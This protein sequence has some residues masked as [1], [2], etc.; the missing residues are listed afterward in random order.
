MHAELSAR[1]V[2]AL[3]SRKAPYWVAPLLYCAKAKLPGGWVLMYVSPI[4]GR[5]V[6]MG[7]G[8]IAT[9]PLK[10]V[11][12]EALEYRLQIARGRCPLTER[13]AEREARNI[14]HRPR[15]RGP[16]SF[17]QAV[18]AFIEAH[19][20]SWSSPKHRLQWQTSLATYAY[21]VIGQM[22]VNRIGVD[23]VLRVIGPIWATKTET[24]SRVR[25]RIE[26]IIDYSRSRKWIAGGAENPA[27][28]KGHLE[29]LLPK[30]SRVS[31]VV[32]QPAMPWRDLP[33]FYQA[34]SRDRGTGALCMRYVIACALRSSEGRLAT[35]DET[36]RD[37]RLHLIPAERTK[38]RTPLRVPLSD[39]ALAI[40]DQ[41]E[42]RRTSKFVFSGRRV[43]KPLSGMAMLEVLRTKAPGLTVHGF[44]S[45]FRD[46]A[47]ENGVAHEIA[48]A[49]LGHAAGNATEAA[50]LRT[51][52]LAK[53]AIVVQR[54]A[55]FLTTPVAK[56]EI[57]TLHEA[58]RAG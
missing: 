48:E 53:R 15:E 52:I 29:N 37:R 33:R 22:P 42:E 2:A 57:V 19:Q 12:E 24:A 14:G 43:G 13:Q 32:H 26:T 9:V 3:P 35:I 40:L 39:E 27:R 46:W 25:N 55:T 11:K 47:A 49:C 20:A 5:R 7:L 45:S 23:E 44:R 17:E 31:P 10:Q 30:K 56:A 41:A 36:D 50:Y 54:W 8:S 21:P 38:T 6:E 18:E 16:H 58:R 28:W 51:D 1:A 4:R 34:L